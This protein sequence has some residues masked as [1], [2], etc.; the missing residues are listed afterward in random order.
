MRV[1][2]RKEGMGEHRIKEGVSIGR[3]RGWEY[4]GREGIGM[5]E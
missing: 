3:R 2:Q 5:I 4:R 1:R